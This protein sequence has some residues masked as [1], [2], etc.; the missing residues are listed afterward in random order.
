[1]GKIEHATVRTNGINMH[2]ASVGDGPDTVLFIHGFPELW[3]SWRHQMVSLAALGYRA[4]APDLRGYGGT[5]APPRVESYTAFHA[6]GDLV[7]MLD[8]LGIGQAFVVGHDWGAIIAWYLCLLRPDRVK[9][10]VNTSV[11]WL[12]RNPGR[13]PIESMRATFGDDYYVCRFQEPGEAEEDFAK[14]DAAKLLKLFLTGRDPR[15]PIVPKN[16]GFSGL[17]KRSDAHQADLPSW[18]TE[19]DIN[20]YAT[21]FSRTGFTGG[22]NYYRCVDLNWELSAPWTGKR[23]EV[24]VKF[25]VGDLD[26]TYHMPGAKEYIHGG[27]FKRAVPNLE[28]VV[29][30]EGVAHFIQQEKPQEVTAHIHDFIKKFSMKF[31]SP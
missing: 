20:Y 17:V 15:P 26:L 7:G 25:I 23:I 8:A 27:G 9:A 13:K 6:V 21:Q 22:F 4:V 24:P 10:L 31:S 5:D 18:L 1:M 28:E 16:Q 29:V 14:A 11:A 2:V 12:P 30:M 19:D 3:Y